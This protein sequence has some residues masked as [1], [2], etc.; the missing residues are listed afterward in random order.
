LPVENAPTAVERHEYV[1]TENA[2]TR[3]SYD[4]YGEASQ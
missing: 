1:V 3:N 4:S 2:Q